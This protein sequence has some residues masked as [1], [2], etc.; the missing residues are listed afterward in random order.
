[1]QEIGLFNTLFALVVAINII[2]IFWS[3]VMYFMEM[4][5]E[6]GKKEYKSM[7]LGSVTSLFILMCVYALIQWVAGGLGF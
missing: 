6:E 3:M 2:A 4:G 1:M 7:L 5:S